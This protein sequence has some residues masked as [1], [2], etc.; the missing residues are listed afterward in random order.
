M[1][2]APRDP[3]ELSR[4]YITEETALNGISENLTHAFRVQVGNAN[5]NTIIPLLNRDWELNS[6]LQL[7]RLK[8]CHY[9]ISATFKHVINIFEQIILSSYSFPNSYLVTT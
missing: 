8:C 5:I 9:T 6:S 1:N 4:R 7:R 3:E 2:L